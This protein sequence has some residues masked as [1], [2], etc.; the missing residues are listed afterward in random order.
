MP[1]LSDIVQ[2]CIVRLHQEPGVG[3]QTYSEDALAEAVE[4][5]FFVLFD[6]FW[7]A[8]YMKRASTTLDAVGVPTDDLSDPAGLGIKH[9]DDIVLT[10][11][12]NCR[13]PMPEYDISQNIN[14][15]PQYGQY[16]IERTYAPGYF[17]VRP[18][19]AAGTTVHLYYKDRPEE[20][21]D[22]SRGLFVDEQALIL[23]ACWDYLTDMSTNK[24]AEVKFEA[25]F[26]ERVDRLRKRLNSGRI[27]TR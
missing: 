5:K 19:P 3:V 11:I 6:M 10:W 16:T 22:P 26:N 12:G 2:R 1:T 9:S 8:Y 24:A 13:D 25:Q 17:V 15:V 23:G 18:Y 20:P 14:A 4:H 7:W 27:S 21:I